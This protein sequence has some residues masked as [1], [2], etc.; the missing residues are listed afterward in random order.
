[1]RVS[2]TSPPVSHLLFADDRMFFCM[3]EPRECNEIMKSLGTY[4]KASGQCINFEKASL[5]FG[6]GIHGHVKKKLK[7]S[8]R[9]GNEVGMGS[10]LGIHEDIS[11][12]KKRFFAF[13][14]ERLQTRVNGW[15]GKWLSRGGG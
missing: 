11:G 4:G 15:T 2:R 10:Y 8:T 5:L 7:S 3:A 12:S 14:K 9:I 6:K 1:M 13:L